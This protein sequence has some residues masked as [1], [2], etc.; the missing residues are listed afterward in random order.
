M[1]LYI[2]GSLLIDKR[3]RFIQLKNNIRSL[4]PIKDTL[5]WSLNL[6]GRFADKATKEI[7]AHWPNAK[8]TN[9]PKLGYYDAIIQQIKTHKRAGA[10]H[11]SPLFFWLEDHWFVCPHPKKFR[12]MLND[13]NDSDTDILTISHLFTSWKN[14][15]EMPTLKDHPDYWI[16]DI[17]L[18][19]QQEIIWSKTPTAYVTG[20]P[21]IYT[22]A[23]TEEILEFNKSDL[24]LPR[25]H[26]FELTHEKAM[27][28]LKDRSFKEMIPKIHVFREVF[29]LNKEARALD[30]RDAKRLIDMRS[31]GVFADE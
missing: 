7:K 18:R 30:Y 5:R 4:L 29:R 8:I 2:V 3:N 12:R 17:N 14:K 15:L 20:L 23:I 27:I 25:P 31:R 6:E 16:L 13:F 11:N 22:I 1:V 26:G 28:F 10:K 24:D 9:T 21:C 19:S